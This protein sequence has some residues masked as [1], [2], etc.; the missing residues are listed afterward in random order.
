MITNDRLVI[1]V[2][3][4]YS[5]FVIF[6]LC[7]PLFENVPTK[8]IIFTYVHW[9]ISPYD[10]SKPSWISLAITR[11]I[12]PKSIIREQL[13]RSMKRLDLWPPTPGVPN[14]FL[15]GPYFLLTTIMLRSRYMINS[16]FFCCLFDFLVGTGG[17]PRSARKAAAVRLLGI[18]DLHL[19]PICNQT[20]WSNVLV[21]WVGP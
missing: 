2:C 16:S 10:L 4:I 21:F 9:Y 15:R 8:K 11:A 12:F 17:M 1:H 5:I 7:V 19:S 18:P 20:A 13:K 3:S 6:A 14:Y